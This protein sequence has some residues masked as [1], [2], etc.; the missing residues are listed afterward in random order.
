MHYEFLGSHI[1]FKYMGISH[2]SMYEIMDEKKDP[3]AGFWHLFKLLH[4]CFL[5]EKL[6][7]ISAYGTFSR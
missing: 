3:R 6:W 2:D 7:K 5:K 4:I 1:D